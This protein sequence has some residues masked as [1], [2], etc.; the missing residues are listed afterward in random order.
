[1][2]RF[3]ENWFS[4]VDEHGNTIQFKTPMNPE[5]V[6]NDRIIQLADSFNNLVKKLNIEMDFQQLNNSTVQSTISTL[7][8][9]QNYTEDKLE[10]HSRLLEICILRSFDKLTVEELQRMQMMKSSPDHE[11][12]IMADQIITSKFEELGIPRLLVPL[13][14]MGNKEGTG[15]IDCD[16]P[17]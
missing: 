1:M 12:H 17:F 9:C 8:S 14:P 16:L 5:K 13:E 7:I 11:N 4:G 10:T 15:D 6:L 3:D 2:G